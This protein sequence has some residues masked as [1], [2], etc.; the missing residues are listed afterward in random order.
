MK[1]LFDFATKELSQ[2]AFLRW[3]FESWEDEDIKP[4]VFEFLEKVGIE[5]KGINE[6]KTVAQRDHIDVTV[7]IYSDKIQALYIE[8]KTTSSE[9]NQ[10]IQYNKSIKEQ[11]KKYKLDRVVKVYYKTS[12]I[13]DDER[14]R[15]NDANWYIFELNDIN[16]FWTKYIHTSNLL[17]RDYSKYVCG[18]CNELNGV[19]RPIDNNLTKW[20][21]YFIN[22]IIPKIKEKCECSVNIRSFNGQYVYLCIR[23]KGYGE[24][25]P[26][27]EIESRECVKNSFKAHLFAYSLDEEKYP[28]IRKNICSNVTNNGVFI[29][30]PKAK[31]NICRTKTYNNL[32]DEQFTEL[33]LTTISE[34]LTIMSKI[35]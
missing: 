33:V 19:E 21:A 9:H 14:R 2:D 34:Y 28:N 18:I 27:I 10:L 20:T 29:A 8:D 30:N 13:N 7:Y 15:I 12:F 31:S 35:T 11:I 16:S 1:N 25:Y 32:K 26:Y 6:I 3:F 4:A 17:L 24:G 23:P 5:T 22:V